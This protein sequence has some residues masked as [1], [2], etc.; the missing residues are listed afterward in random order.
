M[1]VSEETAAANVRALEALRASVAPRSLRLVLLPS[2]GD[3]GRA[4]YGQPYEQRFPD[5][6]DLRDALRPEHFMDDVHLGA[7]GHRFVGERLDEALRD[8]LAA[9]PR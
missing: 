5:A 2:N 3:R 4:D 9:L 1:A 8:T 6:L 7:A